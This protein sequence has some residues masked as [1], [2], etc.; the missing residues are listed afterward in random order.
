VFEIVSGDSINATHRMFSL[1]PRTGVLSLAL[2]G[3]IASGACACACGRRCHR[4][5]FACAHQTPDFETM[6]PFYNITFNIT[7][8]GTALLGAA[9]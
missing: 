6:P 4:T 2:V 5:S 8:D 3:V 1:Q 7:D 9:K